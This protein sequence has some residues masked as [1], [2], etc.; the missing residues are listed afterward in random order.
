MFSVKFLDKNKNSLTVINT[1]FDVRIRN[2]LWET[3][4]AQ[5]TIPYN[6]ET[7]SKLKKNVRKVW[8]IVEIRANIEGGRQIFVG[9]IRKTKITGLYMTFDC[10]DLVSFY[11]SFAEK[12]K[13]L[14][15]QF[16]Q[17]TA[18]SVNVRYEYCPYYHEDTASIVH[19]P[20]Y[21]GVVV[22]E[23]NPNYKGTIAWMVSY[24]HNLRGITEF[25]IWYNGDMREIESKL[26]GPWDYSFFDIMMYLQWYYDVFWRANWYYMDIIGTFNEIQPGIL[27][28][29]YTDVIWSDII[30]FEW[31]ESLDALLKN[32]TTDDYPSIT[33]EDPERYKYKVGN[34]KAIQINTQLD[35][36]T[37]GYVWM[38]T[39][40]EIKA[41]ATKVEWT[42]K[43]DNTL[44]KRTKVNLK[45][46]LENLHNR[47][48]DGNRG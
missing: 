23:Y 11:R 45:Y 26:K 8:N 13:M 7:I 21:G 37:T 12:N 46:V 44:R 1:F 18:E 41:T 30:D 25:D 17:T 33:V 10:I 4:T 6:D 27:K 29:D 5:F 34:K 14:W 20:S 19:C 38:I 3:S 35:E 28:Y 24:Y 2:V 31:E 16:I 15:S 48:I 47:V 43:V 39:E 36:G 22:N 42:I 9:K 32:N 40:I